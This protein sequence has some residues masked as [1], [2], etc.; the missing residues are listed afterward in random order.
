MKARSLQATLGRTKIDHT[1]HD[2][3][4]SLRSINLAHAGVRCL[5]V[6]WSGGWYSDRNCCTLWR[7]S[8]TRPQRWWRMTMLRCC[9]T[10]LVQ[11]DKQVNPLDILL[12]DKEEKRAVA[13]HLSGPDDSN[14]G[15]EE[16][17]KSQWRHQ[18]SLL[19]SQDWCGCGESRRGTSQETSK[20]CRTLKLSGG[21]N[22]DDGLPRERGWGANI[23]PADVTWTQDL[24]TFVFL[25]TA[26]ICTRST[27]R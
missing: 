24:I 5:Q 27:S 11:T 9:G 13:A 6:K 25:N 26:E 10:P 18:S 19:S 1:R 23:S 2:P 20:C 8:G 7:Q 22:G 16:Q 4:C 21:P 12:V 14:I 15:K 3:G 17:E